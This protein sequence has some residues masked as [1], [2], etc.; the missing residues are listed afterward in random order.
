MPRADLSFLT[1]LARRSLARTRLTSD[2]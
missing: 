1:S 2:L